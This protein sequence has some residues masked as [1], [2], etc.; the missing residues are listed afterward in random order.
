MAVRQVGLA[1]RSKVGQHGAVRRQYRSGAEGA[2]R[3]ER[4]QIVAQAAV[5]DRGSTAENAIT[6]EHRAAPAVVGQVKTDRVGRVPQCRDDP[7]ASVAT[8]RMLVSA[9]TVGGHVMDRAGAP[10]VIGSPTGCSTSRLGGN[11]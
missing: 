3:G 1:D 8:T 2:Q 6:G 9:T 5:D 10:R 11:W 7:D 4:V